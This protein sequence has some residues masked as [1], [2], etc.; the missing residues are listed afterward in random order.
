L[1]SIIDDF[2]G[3]CEGVVVL[4]DEVEYLIIQIGFERVIRYLQE[5]K[6]II[7]LNGSR[8]IIPLHKDAIA[9][10]EFSILEKEFQIFT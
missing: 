9:G 6:N 7:V 10:K 3:K 1:N 8:L 2:I 4:L 5:L